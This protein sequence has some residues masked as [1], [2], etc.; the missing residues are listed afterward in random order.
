MKEFSNSSGFVMRFPSR[1][2]SSQDLLG[3]VPEGFIFNTLF[4][5]ICPWCS[6]LE[7]IQ[8]TVA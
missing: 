2:I 4:F 1:L 8:K 7:P 6:I 5:L 3:W